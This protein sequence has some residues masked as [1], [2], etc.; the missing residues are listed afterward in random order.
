MGLIDD[1]LTEPLEK[2]IE[3]NVESIQS[4]RKTTVEE[5]QIMADNILG[6]RNER[7][8]NSVDTQPTHDNH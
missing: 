5:K 1:L 3:S 2:F 7:N 6:K 8:H 4:S